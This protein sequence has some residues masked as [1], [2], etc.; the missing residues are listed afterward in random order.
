MK[1]LFLAGLMTVTMTMML[2]AQRGGPPNGARGG[3]RPDPAAALKAALDLTDAQVTAV[4]ALQQARQDRAQ[5]IMTEVDARRQAL[6]TLLNATSP[7]PTAVGNAAI[8]LRASERRWQPNGTGSS[9]NS[10][11]C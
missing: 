11:S 10:R 2:S 1:R 3:G 4:T 7:D 8:A 9:P 6:D 5:A